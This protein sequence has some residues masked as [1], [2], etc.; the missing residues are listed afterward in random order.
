MIIKKKDRE[1]VSVLINKF[2]NMSS[3]TEEDSSSEWEMSVEEW[4]DNVSIITITLS[5]RQ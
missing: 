3:E 2:E 1:I 4:P 5:L